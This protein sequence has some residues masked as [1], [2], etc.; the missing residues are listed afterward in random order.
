MGFTG[1][2]GLEAAALGKA[3]LVGV[4]LGIYY[5]LFRILR[6]VFHFGYAMILGQDL[7]FWLTGAVGVFFGSV[8][9][10]E[11]Q[12]RILFVL[13]VFGGWG[14]YAATAGTLVITVVD[15]LLRVLRRVFRFLFRHTIQ[16][17]FAHLKTAASKLNCDLKARKIK[18]FADF[19]K[20]RR[21]YAK[22]K[23]ISA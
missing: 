3:L 18:L 16:P 1:N 4:A 14:I 15:F 11:G 12:L 5:D 8:V 22:N 19:R 2:I 23:E 21:K 10:Y 9:V 17:L 6:R 13:A 20:K 7:L